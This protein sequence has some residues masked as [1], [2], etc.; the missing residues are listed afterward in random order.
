VPGAELDDGLPGGI[1]RIVRYGFFNN[2]AKRL[3]GLKRR[4]AHFQYTGFTGPIPLEIPG[5]R[6]PLSPKLFFQPLLEY[7]SVPID[8]KRDTRIVACLHR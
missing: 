4:L 2:A 5:P 1:D 6:D 7:L 8:G 3:K